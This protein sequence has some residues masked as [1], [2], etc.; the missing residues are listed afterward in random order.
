MGQRSGVG[1][2]ELAILEAFEGGAP[3]RACGPSRAG[4]SWGRSK[5]T[6]GWPAVTPS[7]C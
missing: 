3:G 4:E 6:W 2:V 1:L 5:T 7:R